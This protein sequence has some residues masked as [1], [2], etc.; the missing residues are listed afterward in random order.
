MVKSLVLRIHTSLDTYTDKL[1]PG[2]N[3]SKIHF[4]PNLKVNARHQGITDSFIIIRLE[5]FEFTVNGND[6]DCCSLFLV[7]TNA[8]CRWKFW[9]YCGNL[10]FVAELMFDY[11]IDAIDFLYIITCPLWGNF[12]T[13]PTKRLYISFMAAFPRIC[14]RCV[15]EETIFRFGEGNHSMSFGKWTSN[16]ILGIGENNSLINIIVLT[17]IKHYLHGKDVLLW[18]MVAQWHHTSW[19]IMFIICSCSRLVYNC[20]LNTW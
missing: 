12:Y 18:Y 15:T 20:Q 1:K 6:T 9:Y 4:S 14:T 8:G 2:R 19:V 17:T 5:W 7:S 10:L 13:H 3:R 11:T 16:T